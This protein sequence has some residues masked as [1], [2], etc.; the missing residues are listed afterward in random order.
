[1]LPI[2]TSRS[3]NIVERIVLVEASIWFPG[4]CEFKPGV[5]RA[6]SHGLRP[7]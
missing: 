2:Q 1:M 7:T 5:G 4:A 6:Y 3:I